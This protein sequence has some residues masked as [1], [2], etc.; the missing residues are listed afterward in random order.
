MP[1][2]TRLILSRDI[3]WVIHDDSFPS[4]VMDMAD[5]HW[6]KITEVLDNYYKLLEFPR[7]LMSF[8]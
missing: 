8:L 2:R 7:F 4:Q 3:W 6:I 5:L 1:I